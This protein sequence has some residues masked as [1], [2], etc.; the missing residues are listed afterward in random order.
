M[1]NIRAM[2]L[3]RG[4]KLLLEN[5]DITIFPGHHVGLVGRNGT[6]KSSVFALLRHELSVE[7]GDCEVPRGWRIASVKQETPAL[8]RSALEYVLDGDEELRSLEAQ[9]AQAE[10]SNDGH[11]IG[12]LH[13]KLATIGGYDAPSRAAALLNGLGFQPEQIYHPR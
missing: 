13:D 4:G 2:S 7:Q 9:L 3:M 12:A 1:I 6:G 8:E 5:A 11:A 10:K